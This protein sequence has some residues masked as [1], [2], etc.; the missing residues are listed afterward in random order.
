M[1]KQEF[2]G[3]LRKG[4][5]TLPQNDIAEH[6]AFYNEMIDDRMEEGLSEED[7]VAAVGSVEKIIGQIFAESPSAVITKKEHQPGIW[8]IILLVLGAPL[9]LSLGIAAIAVIFS[10]YVSLWS[11]IISLW[12]VFASLIACSFGAVVSGV[13]LL[14]TGSVPGGTA[15]IAAGIL[16]AGLSIFMFFGCKAATAGIV[17]LTKNFGLW[18][19]GLFVRKENVQ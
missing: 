4:L 11:V 10:L 3:Q 12:A 1:R 15:I 19:K 16:C 5:A 14:G 13:V 17:L 18:L 9:W 6:L 8:V 2:L 7:A